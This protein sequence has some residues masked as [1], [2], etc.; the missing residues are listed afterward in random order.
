[1]AYLDILIS[2]PPDNCNSIIKIVESSLA[3]Q[4]LT[5]N[6]QKST[7]YNVSDIDIYQNMSVSYDGF[8]YP[9]KAF[10]R[11]NYT[12]RFLNDKLDS[13]E[14]SCDKIKKLPHSQH[15]MLLLHKCIQ[16]KITYS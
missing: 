11:K 8:V 7:A 5:I 15:A 12:N 3:N 9:G 1:M 4:S 13:L 16:R 14:D 2:T 6:F 10:G